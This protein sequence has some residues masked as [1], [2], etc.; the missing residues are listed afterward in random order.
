[1]SH[2][3]ALASVARTGRPWIDNAIASKP[4]R[5]GVDPTETL[6]R[7]GYRSRYVVRI[8]REQTL[9]GLI[10]F[11]SRRPGFFSNATVSALVPCR[12]LI[13]V[14]VVSEL[15]SQRAMLTAVR[16]AL[17]V[18]HYRDEETGAHL[19]RMSYYAQ[20]I[21]RRVAAKLNLSDE[22]VE[23][24]FQY[25]PLHDIGKVAVPDNILLKPGKFTPEEFEVMKTHVAKGVE[26]IDAMLR[27]HGLEE[28]PHRDLLRNVIGCH[29]ESFDGTGYPHQLS[30]AGIPLEGRIVAVADVFD[31]LTSK[32]P[33][34]EAWT[35]EAAAA[36]LRE[37][38]GGKFDPECV[39]ALLADPDAI[40]DI[41]RRFRDAPA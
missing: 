31:A 24:V 20:G 2:H 39:E 14:L 29:H 35:T 22:Y 26:I 8:Q 33:Y 38:A 15:T 12:R 5:P 18:S 7:R 25:A 30:G 23:Y 4:G 17:Q 41:Q 28:L 13:D 19:D 10:F 32:R 3:P 6:V 11:N 9:Y 1:L 21:A 27:D 34:K 36:F 40:A 16:T 37:Q